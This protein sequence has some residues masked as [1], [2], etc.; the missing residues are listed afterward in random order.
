[1]GEAAMR[2][3][4]KSGV[5]GYRQ[6]AS[7]YF[8]RFA[9]PG[10]DFPLGV[11]PSGSDAASAL[12][13]IADTKGMLVYAMLRDR[14]GTEEFARGLREAAERFAGRFL[15][16]ADLQAAWEKAG[17]ASLDLFFRQWMRRT[18]APDLALTSNTEE[19]G[20]A[21]VTTGTVTQSGD[22]YDLSVE[23]A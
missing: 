5:P 22:L 1:Q 7:Q 11:P 18:G 2:R 3:F 16:L 13:D 15:T 17:G 21:F 8:V 9:G 10:K 19:T 14:I 12:H 6:S 23:I 20:Q 4:L